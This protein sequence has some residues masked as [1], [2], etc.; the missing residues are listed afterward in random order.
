MLSSFF[1][2]SAKRSHK[3]HIIIAIIAV[4]FPVISFSTTQQAITFYRKIL[5]LII[6]IPLYIF[7][8]EGRVYNVKLIELVFCARTRVFFFFFEQFIMRDYGANITRQ[9]YSLHIPEWT[10][11][12]IHIGAGITSCVNKHSSYRWF[13]LIQKLGLRSTNRRM[14]VKSRVASI[15]TTFSKSTMRNFHFSIYNPL[16]FFIEI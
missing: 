16:F 13:T 8:R 6:V 1:N 9:F 15:C 12:S 11:S 7:L 5:H 14:Y 3:N 2:V 4:S 10:P